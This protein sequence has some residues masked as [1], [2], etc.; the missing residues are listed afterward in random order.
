[1]HPGCCRLAAAFSS[2]VEGVFPGCG[3]LCFCRA[4][5]W[6]TGPILSPFSLF[7][8]F[9]LLGS[10]E[11]CLPCAHSEVFSLRSVDIPRELLG[12]C[13][14][15]ACGRRGASHPAAPSSRPSPGLLSSCLFVMVRF[16]GPCGHSVATPGTV[17]PGPS[18]RGIPRQEHWSGLPCPPPGDLPDPGIEPVSLTSP[19]LAGGLFVTSATREAPVRYQCIERQ[20]GFV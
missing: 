7:L 14:R 19:A 6:G 16:P 13:F 5:S 2:E 18:I 1:M 8:S 11:L 4:P 15:C 10:V 17:A 20:R 9:V 3:N 12:V